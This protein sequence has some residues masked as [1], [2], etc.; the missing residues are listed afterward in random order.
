MGELVLAHVVIPVVVIGSV[1]ATVAG[2]ERRRVLGVLNEALR[3]VRL[4]AG[5]AWNA[6]LV[7]NARVANLEERVRHLERV[8]HDHGRELER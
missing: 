4:I 2:R 5:Q 1:L 6:A 7:A 8:A 3:H